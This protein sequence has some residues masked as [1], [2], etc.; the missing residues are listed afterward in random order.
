MDDVLKIDADREDG[1][2]SR[3]FTR[4]ESHALLAENGF[5]V[6]TTR[7]VERDMNGWAYLLV[8]ARST[9]D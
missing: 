7:R 4:D 1:R 8:L 5:A 9:R 2:F 6:T 3:I